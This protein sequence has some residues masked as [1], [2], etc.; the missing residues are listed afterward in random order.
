MI[1]PAASA[2][3]RSEPKN[4]PRAIIRK[5]CDVIREDRAYYSTGEK[6][7]QAASFTYQP[8]APGFASAA[9]R[10]E[11]EGESA[12]RGVEP[13]C[14]SRVHFELDSDGIY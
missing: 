5:R 14:G 2:R 1:C 13:R 4:E 8:A 10:G 12:G 3:W 11:A 6:S 9:R 7:R